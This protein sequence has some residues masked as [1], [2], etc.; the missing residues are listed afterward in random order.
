MAE[1]PKKPQSKNSEKAE[2]KAKPK[3]KDKVLASKAE[4]SSDES[5]AKKKTGFKHRLKALGVKT[6]PNRRLIVLAGSAALASLL[7]TIT[8]FGVM[9]YKY[10]RDDRAVQIAAN[11]VPYPVLSVNGNILWNSE[12]YA[13][14]LFELGS[15]KKFYESQGQDLKT[16]EGKER[17]KQ[18]KEELFKQLTDQQIISQEA[19]KRKIT[20]SS[21]EVDEEFK[22][23]TENAGGA[24]KV[25]ETLQKLYGWTVEDFKVKIKFN[26]IQKKLADKITNDES[27]NAVSKAKAEDLLK[28]INAG[29]D[30]AE[31]AKA[32]S[33]DTS[34][35]SGGD[36]GLIEKGQTVKEFEDA[37]FGLEVGK[38]SGVVKTQFGYHIIKVTDKKDDKVQVS[39][40][41][42]KGIDLETWLKEQREKA[43]IVRYFKL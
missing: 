35:S 39:H 42:I 34:A 6:G 40:I 36:L 29:A 31:I 8:V 23:L 1:S 2:S 10:Q 41:L 25:K 16:D 12:T 27:R 9:I 14:Y 3:A 24:D 22:K 30:F 7:I 33:E 5:T 20:V 37:A 15:V 4:T 21:K 26:L 43:K 11:I 17:L 38:V 13:S 28:Q 18:L 19:A 32:N